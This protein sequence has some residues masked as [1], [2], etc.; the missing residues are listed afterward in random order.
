MV[1]SV[2]GLRFGGRVPD[3]MR[4][5]VV[6]VIGLGT[7]AIGLRD[8]LRTDNMIFPLLGMVFGVIIGEALHVEDRVGGIGARLQRRFA[9]SADGSRFVNGF[10]TASL[11]YLVGPLTVLGAIEDG[12]GSTPNLY[13]IKASLDGFMSVVFASVYGIG[14]L[15]SALSVLV[16]QGSLTILGLRLDE[17]LV[18]RIESELYASGG[19]AVVGIGLNLLGITKI[20]VGSMLPGLVL[21]PILVA[22]FADGLRPW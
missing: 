8:I 2:V 16:V 4:D 18:P 19:L 13:L 15:F 17:I 1:G 10:L 20:R 12:S 9:S 21:T 6:K 22:L 5:S 3:Q 7:I 14:V 11:L